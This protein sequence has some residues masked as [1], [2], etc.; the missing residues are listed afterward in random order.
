MIWEVIAL[1][2]GVDGKQHAIFSN[3]ADPTSRKTISEIESERSGHYD[4]VS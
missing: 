2:V 4:R 3:I 1:Y